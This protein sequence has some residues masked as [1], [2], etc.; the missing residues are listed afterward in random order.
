MNVVIWQRD[1]LLAKVYFKD[2]SSKYN[3]HFFKK[4]LLGVI[5]A[6]VSD[7]ICCYLLNVHRSWC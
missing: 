7:S 1:C 3:V 2:G 4:G 5:A 6:G